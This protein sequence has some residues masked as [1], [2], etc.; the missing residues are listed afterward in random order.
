MSDILSPSCGSNIMYHTKVISYR[1]C[2]AFRRI[3]REKGKRGGTEP[4]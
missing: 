2:V 3:P 4:S 1:H